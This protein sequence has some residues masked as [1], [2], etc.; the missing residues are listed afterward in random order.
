MT[1]DVNSLVANTANPVYDTVI[2]T[3]M[4]TSKPQITK[5][6]SEDAALKNAK[7]LVKEWSS[8]PNSGYKIVD[9]Y[10]I[11]LTFGDQNAILVTRDFNVLEA[12]LSL[13]ENSLENWG[14]RS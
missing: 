3:L 9:D 12:S 5:F 7:R 4:D 11:M 1:F 10:N 8:M 6:P 2:V 14:K 13:V